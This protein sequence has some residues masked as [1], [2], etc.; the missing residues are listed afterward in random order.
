MK[1]LVI[2]VNEIGEA[3]NAN[4]GGE[5]IYW[6][7]QEVDGVWTESSWLRKRTGLV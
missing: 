7:L 5:G 3:D 4:G 6:V 1:R 2:C